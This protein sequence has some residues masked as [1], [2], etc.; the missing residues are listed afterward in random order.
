MMSA[1]EV[2]LSNRNVIPLAATRLSTKQLCPEHDRS[3]TYISRIGNPQDACWSLSELQQSTSRS[4]SRHKAYKLV[5]GV[6]CLRSVCNGFGCWEAC[7]QSL[8]CVP[9][10]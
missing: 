6:A 3:Y 7:L 2:S 10:S 4:W 9:C 8:V 1:V 5:I